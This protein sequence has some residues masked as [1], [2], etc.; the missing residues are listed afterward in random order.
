MPTRQCGVEPAQ[1]QN[2]AAPALICPY[3]SNMY[4]REVTLEGVTRHSRYCQAL[5]ARRDFKCHRCC[6]MILG[7]AP[8][9]SWHR[10]YFR[11]KLGQ[12]QRRFLW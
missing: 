1:S 2:N 3:N 11:K 12:V 6:E 10:E 9:G 4:P 7:A 8:R 5:F